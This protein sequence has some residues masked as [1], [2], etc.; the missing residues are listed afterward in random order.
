MAWTIE[1]TYFE[2]CSCDSLS[3]RMVAFTA[4]AT[5]D[6]CYRDVAF[7]VRPRKHEGVDVSGLSFAIVVDS[8][9]SCF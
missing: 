8:H 6:R 5:H 9:R 7:H 2:N 4:K 1:G 3:V